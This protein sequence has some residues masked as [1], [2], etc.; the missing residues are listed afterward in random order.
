MERSATF[1]D[2]SLKSGNASV[3]DCLVWNGPSDECREASGPNYGAGGQTTRHGNTLEHK[4]PGLHY[5]RHHSSLICHTD[6]GRSKCYGYDVPDQVTYRERPND[7]SVILALRGWP[8]RNRYQSADAAGQ[9]DYGNGYSSTSIYGGGGGSYD[10][11]AAGGCS[12]SNHAS[13]SSWQTPTSGQ[14]HSYSYSTS[15]N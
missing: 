8:G 4:Y 2:N 3:G 12:C 15:Y 13:S 1:A 7:G 11:G 6:I 5:S 14:S 10:S 9:A